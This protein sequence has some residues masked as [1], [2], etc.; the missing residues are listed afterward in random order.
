[1]KI[2]RMILISYESVSFRDHS[3]KKP[4]ETLNRKRLYTKQN[5]D[6]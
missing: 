2:I 5:A 4:P 3:R 6:S 1:M